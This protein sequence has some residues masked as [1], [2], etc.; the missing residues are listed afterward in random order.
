MEDDSSRVCAR[1]AGARHGFTESPEFQSRVEPGQFDPVALMADYLLGVPLVVL[2]VCAGWYLVQWLALIVHELGHFLAARWMGFAVMEVQLGIGRRWRAFHLAGVPW[3]VH[4]S[5]LRGW[6][7]PQDDAFLDSP[8]RGSVVVLAGPAATIVLA[9][10]VHLSFGFSFQQPFEAFKPILNGLEGL[11]LRGWAWGYL[12]AGLAIVV[13]N[14]WGTLWLTALCCLFPCRSF[15]SS[16]ENDGFLL[17]RI[18]VPRF[19]DRDPADAWKHQP[20]G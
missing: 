11:G 13:I 19:R 16:F 3:H 12:N 20:P 10:V 15:D 1:C 17:L 6:V 2:T 14:A 7:T 5:P 8:R 4:F 18:L 9:L